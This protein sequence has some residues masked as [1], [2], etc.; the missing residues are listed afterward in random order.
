VWIILLQTGLML[1]HRVNIWATVA[2]IAIRTTVAVVVI[3]TEIPTVTPVIVIPA[4]EDMIVTETV[5]LK[6]G[7]I[8]IGAIVA[9]R[10]L[11]GVDGTHLTTSGARVIQGAPLEVVAPL[12]VGGTMMVSPLPMGAILV[13]KVVDPAQ[14]VPCSCLYRYSYRQEKSDGSRAKARARVKI[15][16]SGGVS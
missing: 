4:E 5:I 9:A 14:G 2:R 12:V 8:G 3:L 11:Q 10:S 6:A 16:P 7:I 1:R 13:G 15:N